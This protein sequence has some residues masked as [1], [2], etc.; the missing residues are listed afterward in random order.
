MSVIYCL[1]YVAIHLFH[2]H[3]TKECRFMSIFRVSVTFSLSSVA[4]KCYVVHASQQAVVASLSLSISSSLIFWLCV[5]HI[6]Q[7]TAYKW[8]IEESRNTRQPTQLAFAYLRIKKKK[9]NWYQMLM[10]K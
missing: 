7:I 8:F 10:L 4:I 2:E 9:K 3:V 1:H 5:V 6:K